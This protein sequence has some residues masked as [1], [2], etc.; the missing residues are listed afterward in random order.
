MEIF[1]QIAN[2]RTHTHT[3]VNRDEKKQQQTNNPMNKQ[4]VAGA[5]SIDCNSFREAIKIEYIIGQ[6]IHAHKTEPKPKTTTEDGFDP[7]T[8]FLHFIYSI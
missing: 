8:L 1:H 6:K 3:Q 4:K 7:I 5:I 2:A